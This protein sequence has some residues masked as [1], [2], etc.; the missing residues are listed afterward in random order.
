MKEVD[1]LFRMI[2]E[3]QVVISAG[4][5]DYLKRDS[6]YRTFRWASQVHMILNHEMTCV[7]LPNI[8]TA[9]YGFSY[10][11][12]ENREKPYTGISAE[13]RQPYEILM[14]HGGDEKHVPVQKEE[15]HALGYAYTAL[16]HIHK[17]Q[18]LY[19]DTMRYAGA[20]EPIDKN[21]IGSHG[22]IKGEI[23][24]DGVKTQFVPSSMRE[25]RHESIDVTG[26]MTGYGVKEKIKELIEQKGVQDIYKIC[27]K[28]F[29]DPDILFDLNQMDEYGNIVE[30]TDETRP[31]YDLEKLREQNKE[32]ILGLLI[33]EW[34]SSD[35]DS[36]EYQ[37][38]CEGV[39]AL[40]ETRRG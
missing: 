39:Q 38:L 30:I 29:R 18:V 4:N 22:Y 15:L 27:L 31:E 20:L 9:V 8:K 11:N 21:D 40:I 3:T 2:P 17:P 36:L 14:V 10:V 23:T 35:K 1:H 37:A 24:S 6:Y 7:E 28:G 34:G 26:N 13:H 5:H 25:Y 16:G 19:P 32:N 12:R 33:E